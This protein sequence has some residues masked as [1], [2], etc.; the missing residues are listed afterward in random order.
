[1]KQYICLW[2]NLRTLIFM[3][4]F[5]FNCYRSFVLNKRKVV[6]SIFNSR[7]HNSLNAKRQF[8]QFD[9]FIKAFKLRKSWTTNQYLGDVCIM[10]IQSINHFWLRYKLKMNIKNV[11]NLIHSAMQWKISL[12]KEVALTLAWTYLK[13]SKKWTLI[14][15]INL[16]I[17]AYNVKC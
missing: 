1:M 4:E 2:Y 17:H 13:Q 10:L 5:E 16:N 15:F 12:N 3:D 8:K 6:D 11:P 7:L 14:Q 9:K